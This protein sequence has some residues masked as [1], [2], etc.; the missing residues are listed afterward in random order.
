MSFFKK[1]YFLRFFLFLFFLLFFFFHTG[2]YEPAR[3]IIEGQVSDPDTEILVQWDSGA[4]FNGYESEPFSFLP[5]PSREGQLRTLIL[6]NTGEKN[7]ASKG[8]RLILTEIRVDGQGLHIPAK[9][10]DKVRKKKGIG[11]ILPDT[12]AQISLKVPAKKHLLLTLKSDIQAGVAKIVLD[13]HVFKHDL[14]R[15]NWAI[16]A[17]KINYWLLDQDGGFEVYMDMPR[18]PVKQLQIAPLGGKSSMTV[19]SVRL[20][21]GAN[22]RELL[23]SQ[24]EKNNLIIVEEP[25]RFQKKLFHP[26]QCVLQ[27]IFALLATWIVWNVVMLVRRSN[28]IKGLL[29]QEKRYIFWLFLL[30][31]SGVFGLW[32]LAFWPG[33]LSVDSLNVWRS[34]WLPDVLI[35]DHPAINVF[36]YM[37]LLHFWNNPAVVPLVQICLLSLLLAGVLFYCFRQGV[38]LPWLLFC[39]ACV[40][41]SVPV[42]LYNVTLWKDVPFALLV[43]FWAIALVYFYLK[44]KKGSI[45]L[46]KQQGSALFFLFLALIFV[47]HNGAL[48]LFALP[49]LLFV[50]GIIK[51]NRALLAT[52]CAIVLSLFL[53]LIFPPKSLK[54]S[55]YLA[56]LSKMYL[57]QLQEE[58][59]GERVKTTIINYPYILDIKENKKQSD[60]WHFYL[61]DRYA[62]SFLKDADWNDT[63]RY[64]PKDDLPFPR[65]KKAAL[66]LYW[67]SLDYPWVYFS[68]NPFYLPLLFVLSII[69][70]RWFPLSAVYSSVILV[71]ILAL[72]FYVETLNWRYYFFALVGGL[73]LLP[74]LLLDVRLLLSNKLNAS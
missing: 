53:L 65:L 48:Y 17:A 7:P 29:F 50:F 49:V 22:S 34:A 44:K 59:L 30:G 69:A 33:V 61:G 13:N 6:R 72:L 16:L 58:P 45:H 52:G 4:G 14:Y 36:F 20:Q 74:V 66:A 11:W 35:N 37:F 67:K 39:W 25:T 64:L 41:L 2:W 46:T 27:I 23:S 26:F 63:F 31:S 19:S 21:T 12:G 32:L 10:L 28:G 5:P 54:G 71:Q 3:L 57:Q 47:R 18:Y 70:Y 68:W 9:S 1:T 62:Y 8:K 24:P 38:S 15:S 43:V 60:F 40:V 51:V 55:S 42:G 73:F 56:D